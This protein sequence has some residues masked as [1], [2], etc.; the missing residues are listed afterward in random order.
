MQIKAVI[1][2]DNGFL[3]QTPASGGEG[4]DGIDPSVK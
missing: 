3:T 1:L 2:Y 4:L